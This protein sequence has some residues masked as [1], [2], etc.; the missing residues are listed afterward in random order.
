MDELRDKLG[1]V[2]RKDDLIVMAYSFGRS[3]STLRFG[4]V[5]DIKRLTQAG[6]PRKEP[7]VFYKGLHNTPDGSIK[8]SAMRDRVVKVSTLPERIEGE[9]EYSDEYSDE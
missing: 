4:R 3:S 8:E 1:Q 6:K 9:Y 2:V 5:T 7:A